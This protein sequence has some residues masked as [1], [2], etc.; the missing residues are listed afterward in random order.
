MKNKNTLEITSFSD[1][2]EYVRSI[3]QRN[4]AI[5]GYQT[6]LSRAAGCTPSFLS[7]VLHSSVHLTPDHG[8][9]LVS[10]W[11]LPELD[12]DYFMALIHE[13]RA[14]SPQLRKMVSRTKEGIRKRKFD[15]AKRFQASRLTKEE[16][17]FIYYSGWQWSAIHVLLSIPKYQ[18]ASELANRLGMSPGLITDYI[19]QLQKMGLV[20]QRGR[21]F[22]TVEHN[23][24]LPKESAVGPL[25]HLNWRHRAN[26]NYRRKDV[27]SIH[28][29]AVH[30]LSVADADR[31]RHLVLKL[32]EESRA[33]VSPSKEE[34]AV[35]FACD[36]FPI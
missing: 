12:A 2:K 33:I 13:A 23:V 31:I 9:G 18:T 5:R 32:I 16:S 1:Y 6:K 27:D 36:F 14:A 28:Y 15:L 10:F 29:T 20:A 25:H 35:C 34:E 30:G 4:A 3:V 17:E 7:Q 21:Q 22:R 8:A 24:H 11:E 26:E 19:L